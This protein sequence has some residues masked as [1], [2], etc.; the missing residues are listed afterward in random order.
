MHFAAWQS[1]KC[2]ANCMGEFLSKLYRIQYPY[3][4][5][6]PNLAAAAYIVGVATANVWL[7]ERIVLK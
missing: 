2:D 7:T 5:A 3:S 1:S 6:A 4:V